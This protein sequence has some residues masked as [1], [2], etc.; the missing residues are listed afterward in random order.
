MAAKS[1]QNISSIGAF[2]GVVLMTGTGEAQQVRLVPDGPEKP[3]FKWDEHRCR[4]SLIPDT[5]A[6]AFRRADGLITLYSGNPDN[7]VLK[8]SRFDSLTP[9]CSIILKSSDYASQSLGSMY[10]E[11]TYTPDG[12]HVFGLVSQDLTQITKERG[13]G[14]HG[15]ADGCWINN[16]L[17]VRSADMG[18]TFSIFPE[19]RHIIASLGSGHRPDFNRASGFFVASNIFTRG[20]FSYVILSV[21]GKESQPSGNCLF[22]TADPFDPASWRA[23]DGESFSVIARPHNGKNEICKPIAPEVL[24]QAVRSVIY[25]P[26]LEVWIATFMD[27]LALAGDTE[28]VPG[29]Y[30]STSKDLISWTPPSRIQA[31]PYRPRVDSWEKMTIYPSLLDPESKSRNFDTIDSDRPILIYTVHY[32]KNGQGTLNRDLVYVPLRIETKPD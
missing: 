9:D 32:L 16:I 7:W 6:R 18:E 10:L 22:R 1:R 8:G 19:N 20:A 15:A 5:A 21:N 24:V 14:A 2:F 26:K 17:A 12:Q 30:M 31:S 13:C 27:R 3:I 11:A 4:E 25:A 29:F 23:W 28:R